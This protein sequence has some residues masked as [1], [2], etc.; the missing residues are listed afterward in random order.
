MFSQEIRDLGHEI[1]KLSSAASP[2]LWEHLSPIK[3]NLLSIADDL[4]VLEDIPL[5]LEDLCNK[6]ERLI[7]EQT[8]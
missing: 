6:I 7:H 8:K 4:A 2:E 5:A 3:N 1:A